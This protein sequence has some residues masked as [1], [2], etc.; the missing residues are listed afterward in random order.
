MRNSNPGTRQK[1]SS[2]GAASELKT[3]VP[4]L[5]HGIASTPL[6]IGDE[7]SWPISGGL[8]KAL[9]ASNEALQRAISNVFGSVGPGHSMR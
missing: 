1:S 3:R 7:G 6:Q 4:M 8:L 5:P 9:N 2:R